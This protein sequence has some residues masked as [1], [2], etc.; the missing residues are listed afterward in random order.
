MGAAPADLPWGELGVDVVI[1]STGRFTDRRAR[2]ATSS[3][4]P[5]RRHLRAVRRRGRHLRHGRERRRLRPR[6]AP[7]RL[8]RLVHDQLLRADGEGARRRLRGRARA[9]DDG[10]RLH[11]RPEARSTSP[12]R[13]C[14]GPVP[15]PINIVPTSTGAARATGLVLQA[16][17]G[18]LDGI[19]LRVP[20]PDG[21]ITDFTAS[22]KAT[23]SVAEVNEAFRPLP[24]TGRCRASSSTPRSRSSRRTSS[25][26]RRR[27][28]STR[29]LT[30]AIQLDR[31]ASSL[32]KVFGWYDNEW[33]YSNRLVDLVRL[34]GGR[35]TPPRCLDGLPLLDDLGDS[36]VGASSCASTSTCPLDDRP[37]RHLR[38][39]G[40][41]PD[42]RQPSRRSTW[43]V[44]RGATVVGCTHLG[45]PSGTRRPVCQWPRSASALGRARA[46]ASSSWRTSGSIPGEEANDPAFVDRLVEGFDCLRERR[47]RA[48][49]HRA[50]AS[51]VGPPTRLPSAAGR[52]ARRRGRGADRP[53][54]RRR[55]R[56][57]VA[58]ARRRQGGR[59]ARR[60]RRRRARRRRAPRRRGDG[61]HL[62]RR[63]GPGVGASLSTPRGWR[64]CRAVLATTA[65]VELPTD[66]VALSPGA[67]F[68]AGCDGRR[69]PRLRGRP[70][71]GLG[72]PRHRRAHDGRVREGAR[73][74]PRPS[75][76]TG[77]WAPSR[78]RASRTGPRPSPRR[79]PARTPTASSAAATA[80]ARSPPPGSPT[81]VSFISTGG[82]A[83]LALL[84]H[85]D[86]PGLAALR[87][88][89]NAHGATVSA[90]RPVVAGNW[91]LHHDHV[92]AIHLVAQLAVLL[93]SDGRRRRRHGAPR[94]RSRTCARSRA[95]SRPTAS[96]CSSAPST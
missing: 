44:E 53:P 5:P 23:S 78:T 93:R 60:R 69:G 48:S 32:V 57:F 52:R 59:Q 16:M 51:V 12:T 85:G 88:A 91:K 65:H 94:R 6:D 58:V 19:S 80:S 73:R 70:P 34:V 1:E 2:P 22:C 79:R 49:A 20:V 76:G 28:P 62:P 61:L 81:D 46:R 90:R 30:H 11:E 47:L 4:G 17:K 26:R 35:V 14:A 37:R 72:G 83:T 43:L 36:T 67:R 74:A 64:T 86:L 3:R 15:P 7:R 18:R 71:R 10:P 8:Q 89:P 39:R 33:G 63:P 87:H 82:G 27:A 29:A 41:L 54:R 24:P 92:E 84:E 21:S 25:A 31:L 68:G 9:H 42:P 50:H 45:R 66:V 77:R 55:P 38:R 95:S 13:T 75:C 96:R 56:P 40:R